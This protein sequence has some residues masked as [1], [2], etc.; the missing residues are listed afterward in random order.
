MRLIDS[1]LII[2]T[3]SMDQS[4]HSEDSQECLDC[5]LH[6]DFRSP[7]A[8]EYARYVLRFDTLCLMY[9]NTLRDS[10]A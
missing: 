9:L 7:E 1:S 4:E 3:I 10:M 5:G 6:L 2:H 8:C